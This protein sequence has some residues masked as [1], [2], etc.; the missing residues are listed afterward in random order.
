MVRACSID[1]ATL[2]ICA[3]EGRDLAKRFNAQCIETSA[4]QRVNV[5]EAFIAVVRAIRRYQKVSFKIQVEIAK[6]MTNRSLARHKQAS[7]RPASHRQAVLAVVQMITSQI[8]LI[9][10][11]VEVAS[12]YEDGRFRGISWFFLGRGLG[13]LV[14]DL[15]SFLSIVRGF[16]HM[17]HC[18]IL[19]CA[20]MHTSIATSE[21][22]TH[23]ILL[24]I[25]SLIH[26]SHHVLQ[27]SIL[28]SSASSWT[29]K[30]VVTNNNISPT[31]S[32][33]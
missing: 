18:L 24:M 4:K 3:L 33:T 5:D 9:K 19:L 23:F 6:L 32:S 7:R 11:V 21:P 2:L 8:T 10:G 20:S 26:H 28:F 15:M 30:T 22:V 27:L 16:V 29:L 14:L 17:L 12:C 1:S 13:Y 31:T 25:C